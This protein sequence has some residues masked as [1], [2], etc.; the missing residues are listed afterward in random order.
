[1]GTQI[2]RDQ[3][4]EKNKES[5]KSNI[6]SVSKELFLERGFSQTN[7]ADIAIQAKISRKTLYRYFSSKE[8]IAMEI[9]LGVFEIFVAVQEQYIQSLEGNGY[10]KLTKYL[11]K[12]DQMVDEY[13]QL[14]RFTGM[15]DTYLVGEY[16]NT[17][18]QRA[19]IDLIVKV[20]QPFIEFLTEG[21]KDGSI[22]ADTEVTYL[23]RTISNSFLALAQRI[24]T[25]QTH[26]NE[27]QHIDSRKILSVQRALFL[28]A[29]KG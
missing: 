21:I 25:R 8:E 2:Y 17:E 16:P 5:V 13:S 20:D 19:F 14:L 24:V 28:K 15:F 12:L 27:E 6:V 4:R 7:M 9:E 11:E 23:A 1:M 18:S 3:E 29:L 22:V 26:L 10:E